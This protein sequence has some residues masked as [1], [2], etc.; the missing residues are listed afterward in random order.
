[1][2]QVILGIGELAACRDAGATIKTFALGSC[3]AVICFSPATR[4]AGMVHVALPDSKINA[5]KSRELP[6][7]FADTG[8]PFLL[9]EMAVL[10]NRP[11]GRG[12]VVK[13]IGGASVMDPNDVF[14]IGKR[15]LLAIRKILWSHGLGAIAE[16]VGGNYSRTVSLEVNT[17]AVSVFC[18]GRGQWQV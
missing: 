11:D 10:G 13:L 17:G 16:D 9:R 14:S 6:G 5:E 7:Y 2:K 15:N 12:L 3:I 1:M 18:P 4:T 8:I